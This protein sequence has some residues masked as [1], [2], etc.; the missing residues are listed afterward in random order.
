MENSSIRFDFSRMF[1]DAVG[2]HGISRQAYAAAAAQAPA[3]HAAMEAGRQ[4]MAWR[5]LPYEQAEAVAACRAAAARINAQCD[6]FVVLG[7]GGSALGSKALFAACCHSHYNQLPRE[8]RG[9]ARFYVEDNVDP[10]RMNA[11]FDIIDVKRTAFHVITKSG[12]TVETMAQFIIILDRLK[13]ALGD[14]Y[15]NNLFITTDKSQGIMKGIADAQGWPTFTVPDGVGGRFSV[16]CPVGL[17]SAAV[18]NLD[19]DA[20]LAGAAAMDAAC[21][22]PVLAEN[23]AYVYALLYTEAMRRGMNISVLMPYADALAPFAEWYCQLW[24]ESLGKRADRAGRAVHCGQTPVRALGVTDQHSQIQLYNEG[25]FDKVIGFIGVERFRS[26]LAIPAAPLDMRDA[27]YLCGHSLNELITAELAATVHAVTK[28]GKP[29]HTILVET[30]NEASL[31]KLFYFYEMA[32]AAAGELL[33]INAFDQP[34]VE[35]GKIATFALMG[36]PGYEE[37]AAALRQGQDTGARLVITV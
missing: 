20:L 33:Q 13:Q 29:N 21:G 28:N 6:N 7:I 27:A 37:R 9:G 19:L 14:D 3:L 23:P 11:L 2:A 25:P 22:S 17:L 12:N 34:G 36:R 16:L 18:L 32:T 10:E 8:R 15:A 5:R 30:L 26:K 1:A 31:G 4:A 24:A 35:E